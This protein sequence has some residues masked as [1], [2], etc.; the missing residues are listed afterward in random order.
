MTSITTLDS[1]LAAL[2]K[3]VAERAAAKK[4]AGV[5]Q[6]KTDAVPTG[7]TEKAQ[8]VRQRIRNRLAGLDLSQPQQQ[9]KAAT[10]FL[11][12]VL[13]NEFGA[14]LLEDPVFH[15]LLAEVRNAMLADQAT[16]KD[17]LTMLTELRDSA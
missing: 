16:Q 6:Q 13:A 8:Q 3:T 17:F 7:K 15:D 1:T 9:E 14:E 5:G 10:V 12:T 4:S 2:R 11:E